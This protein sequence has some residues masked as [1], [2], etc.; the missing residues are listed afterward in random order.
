MTPEAARTKDRPEPREAPAA[1]SPGR[2][3]KLPGPPTDAPRSPHEAP[4]DDR[5]RDRTTP[6]F[7]QPAAVIRLTVGSQTAGGIVLSVACV[8]LLLAGCGGADRRRFVAGGRSVALV[9]AALYAAQAIAVTLVAVHPGAWPVSQ[10]AQ[11]AGSAAMISVAVAIAIAMLLTKRSLPRHAA[12][13]VLASLIATKIVLVDIALAAG[14][15]LVA[16]GVP[17]LVGGLVAAAVIT[18]ASSQDGFATSSISVFVPAAILMM[19]GAYTVV[20]LRT[21]AVGSPT[22]GAIV[23]SVACVLLLLAGCGVADRRRFVAGQRSTWRPRRSRSPRASI[24]SGTFSARG[25]C[26]RSRARPGIASCRSAPT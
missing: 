10:A 8:L 18:R 13:L 9:V 24:P 3:S 12:M 20:P 15:G 1:T 4:T 17:L 6:T 11:F 2:A 5:S 14:D 26:M 16:V 22:A 19:I 7:A 23:L 21:L 25:S